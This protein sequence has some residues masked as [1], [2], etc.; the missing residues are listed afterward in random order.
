MEKIGDRFPYYHPGF[1]NGI[2]SL[3]LTGGLLAPASLGYAAHFLGIG[4]VM[5]LPLAGSIFVVVLLLLILL[6]SRL[7]AA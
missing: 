4:V 3:A 6:E 7:S 1:F 5:G 2:F